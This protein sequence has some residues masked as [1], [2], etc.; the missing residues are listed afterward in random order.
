MVPPN[1]LPGR[2]IEMNQTSN[3]S[4]GARARTMMMFMGSPRSH[5]HTG[6]ARQGPTATPTLVNT[7]P[8]GCHKATPLSVLVIISLASRNASKNSDA[9]SPHTVLSASYASGSWQ[10]CFGCF[11]EQYRVAIRAG[12]HGVPS[13]KPFGAVY[14][15]LPSHYHRDNSTYLPHSRDDNSKQ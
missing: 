2:A 5:T 13:E 6:S 8:A 10:C 15:S 1:P 7:R 3:P 14:V 11:G 9:A 12:D 4:I